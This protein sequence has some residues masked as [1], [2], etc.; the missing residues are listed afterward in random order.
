MMDNIKIVKVSKAST[1]KIQVAKPAAIQKKT[2][3]IV[4]LKPKDLQLQKTLVV[5]ESPGKIVKIQSYLGPNYIV[6]ASY[7]HILAIDPNGINIDLVNFEPKYEP[8]PDKKNVIKDLKT[9]YK[10]ATS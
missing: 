8:I 9:A 3:K 7:G 2:D 5:V 10:G 1:K 6:K 4:K